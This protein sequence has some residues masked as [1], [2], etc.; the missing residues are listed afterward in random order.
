MPTWFPRF[1]NP[2]DAAIAAGI[3]A[4]LLLLLYFLKLRRREAAVSSTLLWKKAIQ[5]L[6]VNAPFQKLRRNL[7][8]LLQM[9]LLLFLALA[10]SRPVVNYSPGAGS[11][12]VILIDRSASMSAKDDGVKSRL[13][14]AKAKAKEIV[15]SMDSNSSAAVVAFDD[16][17][18]TVQAFTTDGSR[19]RTQIDSIQPTDRRS[20]LKLA[21]QLAEAQST[22]N[23]NQNRAIIRPDV[24]L[25]SDGRVLD[26]DDLRINGNVT[27]VPIGSENT[28][29]IG[30]VSLSAKRNYE[31]PT[32]V[33]IFARLAN[34]GPKPID[35][36]V[37][38]SVAAIDPDKPGELNFIAKPGGFATVT[39]PPARW[40]D[41][42]WVAEHPK[43]KDDN[44]STR[45]SVE[46]N[47]DLTT[48]AVIKVEQM[49]KDGDALAADDTAQVVVPPPKQLAVL[50]VTDGQNP[51]MD[52]ALSSLNLQNVKKI[53]PEEYAAAVPID[54]DV[55]VFDRYSPKTLPPAGS[56]VYFGAYP[57]P[58]VKLQPIKEDGVVAMTSDVRVVDWKRDHPI[59]RSLSL[60]RVGASEA[61]RLK[62]TLDSQVLMDG[63]NGPLIVLHREGRGTHLVIAF[64]VLQSN[65][66]L[67]QSF[68]VF[69]HHVIQFMAIGS[70]MD[71]RESLAPGSTPRI[72]RANLQRQGEPPKQLTISGPGNSV[73]VDIPPTGDF[74]L[75]AL[76]HV[77]VYT[78][79]PPVPQFERM[80]VNLLSDNES[81]LLPITAPPGNIGQAIVTGQST[82]RL[83]LWWWIVACTGIPLLLIE[84]WVYTR[85]V[86][87]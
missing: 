74:A 32:Q 19:L 54:Y 63:V 42:K 41:A 62:P 39:L 65:W 1:L 11:L 76:N 55:I 73:K 75:P 78:L 80:A 5:D 67:M 68:P 7:L 69:M 85:R 37:Q 50:H 8:L 44:Y 56:F 35:A 77:G 40:F 82:S 18:E 64:D 27:Y 72:P 25:F 70:E 49:N 52:L 31:Q 43:Q 45:E 10:F 30:V 24:F 87:L 60:A 4:P 81:N 13:D 71:V 51:Y 21:Y 36:Q 84:W 66:P 79:S 48:A 29:N 59:L 23:P 58:D 3:V 83:E 61:I 53:T 14:V 46:F 86:H 26:A 6:Q 47:I 20:R 34:F 38:L 16:S 57:P 12:T 33:Q 2:R 17:A 28:G 15:S 9:L 22:F